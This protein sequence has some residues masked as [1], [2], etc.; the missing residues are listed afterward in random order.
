MMCI[1]LKH[2][3]C[4]TKE[5]W[6][7]RYPRCYVS[8]AVERHFLDWEGNAYLKGNRGI[9]QNEPTDFSRLSN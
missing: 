1:A 7:L 8:T 3:A 2:G 4:V 9:R 5:K 6:R